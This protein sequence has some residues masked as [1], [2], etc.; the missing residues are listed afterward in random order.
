MLKEE[1]SAADLLA[2]LGASREGVDFFMFLTFS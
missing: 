2:N 1:H